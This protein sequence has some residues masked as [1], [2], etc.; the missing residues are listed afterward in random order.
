MGV[1]GASGAVKHVNSK[2]V[3][4][5]G[6]ALAIATNASAAAPPIDCRKSTST[7]DR[8]IC[9]SGEFTAMDREIA[10]LYDRGMADFTANDRH[11]LAA[12]QVSFLQHRKS[13]DWA[14]HHS[15]HPGVAVE[16]CVRNIMES[17]LRSL[18]EVVDRGRF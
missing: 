4:F 15:A 14:A 5:I 9:G 6:S 13:C 11:R 8:E 7:V 12:S 17:R 16:E 1:G 3:L 18:R 10:A 2:A